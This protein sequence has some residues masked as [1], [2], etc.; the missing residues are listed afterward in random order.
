MVWNGLD[1]PEIE[2]KSNYGDIPDSKKITLE[3]I[4]PDGTVLK[5]HTTYGD[6][7]DEAPIKLVA[8]QF[9]GEKIGG[10]NDRDWTIWITD[11]NRINHNYKINILLNVYV[12]KTDISKMPTLQNNSDMFFTPLIKKTTTNQN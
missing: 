1:L 11:E 2:F 8:N 12:T 10:D 9:Y 3:L 7:R 4:S 6:L 5:H